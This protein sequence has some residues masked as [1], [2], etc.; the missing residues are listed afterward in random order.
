S[1]FEAVEAALKTAKLATGKAGVIVFEGAYHGLG[2]GALNATHRAHFRSPFRDQL[3]EFGHFLPFPSVSRA[4]GSA[5]NGN[6]KC[7]HSDYAS[8]VA[9]RHLETRI[10]DLLRYQPIGAILV[11]PIQ[12]RGGINVPP[13][14]FLLMLRHLCDRNEVLLIVD[15]IYTGLGRTG[16]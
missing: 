8:R 11:E 10:R 5:A 13:P 14:E 2:Y 7:P 12:V 15:E 3:R 9:M 16:K 4:I 1:G 6:P